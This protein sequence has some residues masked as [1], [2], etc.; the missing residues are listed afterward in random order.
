[1]NL[2][3]FLIENWIVVVPVVLFSF[4]V[5]LEECEEASESTVRT[6]GVPNSVLSKHLGSPFPDGFYTEYSK[7]VLNV[8]TT[9]FSFV[10]LFL[11][12]VAISVPKLT[13]LALIYAVIALFVIAVSF[14]EIIAPEKTV[15]SALAVFRGY[16][17]SAGVLLCLGIVIASV[18]VPLNYLLPFSMEAKTV[19]PISP[20]ILR[21]A[22]LVVVIPWIEEGLFSA[23]IGAGSLE[24]MGLV[25]GIV[26]VIFLWVI[27]HF[28]AWGPL[29]VLKMLYLGAFRVASLLPVAKYKSSLPALLGHGFVNGFVFLVGL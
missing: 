3:S 1:M 8:A 22:M 9:G 23:T 16:N 2:L 17:V 25:P 26:L 29:T 11:F 27:F 12:W 13:T 15:S 18:F 28:V 6:G 24:S 19:A 20:F 7:K 21:L 5:V 4:L 10:L 14:A